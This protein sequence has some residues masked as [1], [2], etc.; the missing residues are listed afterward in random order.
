MIG[1]R[2]RIE[3]QRRMEDVL[4]AMDHQRARHIGDPHDSLDP[5][6]IGTLDMHQDIEP[7][8]KQ[9]AGDGLVIRQTDRSNALVVAVDIVFGVMRRRVIVMIVM[10][11]MIV[12]MVM[13]LVVLIGVPILAMRPVV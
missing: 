11:V 9:Q 2:P 4:D 7:Q 12:I 8:V 5:Q 13:I 10:I 6:Q 3:Q 1:A